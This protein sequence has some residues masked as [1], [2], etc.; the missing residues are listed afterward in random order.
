ME[1]GGI[2]TCISTYP[3]AKKAGAY[4]A[5]FE[6]RVKALYNKLPKAMAGW[7]A[8]LL[9]RLSFVPLKPVERLLFSYPTFLTS[10]FSQLQSKLEDV[11][12]LREI[13][14]ELKSKLQMSFSA[15]GNVVSAMR[16]MSFFCI[17][18]A[19]YCF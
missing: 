4:E 18:I 9:C 5:K 3:D 10:G 19:Q 6:V 2:A 16:A 14:A 8:E 17:H 15:S 13:L 7:N 11:K 12:R 1:T